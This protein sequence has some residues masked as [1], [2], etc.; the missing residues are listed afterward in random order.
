M[1]AR[2]EAVIDSN[3]VKATR[4]GVEDEITYV[5]GGKFLIKAKH[6]YQRNMETGQPSIK[7]KC[8]IQPMAGKSSINSKKGCS[9]HDTGQPS[10]E[11]NKG[12]SHCNTEQSSIEMKNFRNKLRY[13]NQSTVKSWKSSI[14]RKKCHSKSR[15]PIRN[16]PTGSMEIIQFILE[17][18]RQ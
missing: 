6:H 5:N 2:C 8:H 12:C 14:E 11:S 13:A 7:R 9:N 1:T 3:N 10:L 17:E 18:W 15:Y 16:I 4:T